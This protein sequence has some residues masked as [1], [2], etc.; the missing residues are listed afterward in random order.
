VHYTGSSYPAAYTDAYFYGDYVRDMLWTLTTDASG[1]LTRA[2][3]PD[4]FGKGVGLPVAFHPGPNGDITFADLETGAVRRLVY[5]AGNA[6]PVGHIEAT[7]DAATHTVSLSAAD[8]YDPQ[9]DTMTY[10]WDFGDDSGSTPTDETTSHQYA[11]DVDVATVTLTAADQLGAAS[12]TTLAVHPG[13]Y[14][15]TLTLT[16]DVPG[17]TYAVGDHVSL[18]AS[19]TDPED[20]DLPVTWSVA[21][22]HCPYPD[23]CHRHPD[24]PGTGASFDRPFT[25]HGADT[26]MLVTA[27]VLDTVGNRAAATFVA[28]PQLHT[29]SVVSPVPVVL[30]GDVHASIPEV[31]GATVQL[32]APPTSSYWRFAGWSDGGAPSHALTMPDD[33]LALTASYRTAIDL[34]WTA[35]GGARSV[36][37]ASRGTEH[38]VPGGRGR[39]FAHGRM[40]W[41]PATDA[42]YV[43]GGVLTRYLALGGPARLGLPRGDTVLVPGG[44]WS[45]FADGSSIWQHHRLRAWRVSGPVQA[46]FRHRG[47]QRSCLGFPAGGQHAVRGGVQQRFQHGWVRHLDRRGTTRVHCSR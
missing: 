33:D 41:R 17:R 40:Y 45:R 15:P 11:D 22:L 3:E 10:H 27:S 14:S 23:S 28:R 36:L 21:L 38:D 37:G 24:E 47:W 12:T 9:G 19:G 16:G 26:S 4:G 25:D 34:R 31:T 29:L 39:T 18:A 7:V 35:L 1:R 46:A 13:D 30:D 8:S 32:A 20:G 5:D 6:P 2:P 42:I 43:T 44:R